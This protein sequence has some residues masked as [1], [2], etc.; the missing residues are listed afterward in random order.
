MDDGYL[1]IGQSIL[2]NMTIGNDPNGGAIM[3]KYDFDLKE[4][5]AH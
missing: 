2:E 5:M 3:V 4:K 1:V